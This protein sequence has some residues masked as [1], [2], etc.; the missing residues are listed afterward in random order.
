MIDTTKKKARKKAKKKG[1][2]KL[3]LSDPVAVIGSVVAS[4]KKKIKDFETGIAGEPVIYFD[5][6]SFAL[7][8]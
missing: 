6:G 8:W 5:T 7:N 2:K 1:K 3:D 4:V